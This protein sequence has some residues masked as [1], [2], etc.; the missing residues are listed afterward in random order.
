MTLSAGNHTSLQAGKKLSQSPAGPA[1]PIRSGREPQQPWRQGCLAATSLHAHE[2]FR[3]TI[4]HVIALLVVTAVLGPLVAYGDLTPARIVSV[5]L[6]LLLLT[7]FS[8]RLDFWKTW[9]TIFGL[10]YATAWLAGTASLSLPAFGEAIVYVAYGLFATSVALLPYRAS[11]TNL[12]MAAMILGGIFVA[13]TTILQWHYGLTFGAELPVF[14]HN[15]VERVAGI[16]GD[17]NATG[18]F[19][20]CAAVAMLSC[21]V[22]LPQLRARWKI[23]MVGVTPFYGY[24]LYLTVSR[25]AMASLL[26]GMTCCLLLSRRNN[27]LFVLLLAVF[28]TTILNIDVVLQGRAMSLSADYSAEQRK[29]HANESLERFRENM[30]IGSGAIDSPYYAH[31]NFLEVLALGGLMGFVPFCIVHLAIAK[32]LSAVFRRP[33]RQMLLNVFVTFSCVGMGISWLNNVLYWLF[34]GLLL[35]DGDTD[36]GYGVV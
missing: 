5:L 22:S 8:S 15:G 34:I 20:A 25:T 30:L 32:K 36:R 6:M 10:A 33:D 11:C 4:Y 18:G 12:V 21:L 27:F 16:F 2:P 13:I 24:G 35:Q 14:V 31:N 26:A 7:R 19:T 9:P 29:H 23:L 3:L 28:A 17:P 1:G